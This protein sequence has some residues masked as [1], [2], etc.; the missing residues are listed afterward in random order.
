MI[1][2]SEFILTTDNPSQLITDATARL[3]LLVVDDHCLLN[4]T[5]SDAFTESEGFVVD[6]V[7]SVDEAQAMITENGRYDVVLL[8]YNVP[9]MGALLGLSLLINLN[10]GGVVL[11]SGIANRIV[12]ERALEAGASG[13]IPKTLALKTLGHA[14]RL[15]AHGGMY[16]P[17]EFMLRSSWDDNHNLGLKPREMSVLILLCEGMQNKEIGRE[18]GIE[19]SIVKM[20]V[21]SI[22]RKLG[23]RNRTQAAI[24]ANKNGIV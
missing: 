19:E 22:C 4:E 21:K 14:V 16:V 23:V 6:T 3:R 5:L 18:I 15:V 20:D 8:D 7:V 24:A 17:K 13:F 11:F 9:G 1:P 2:E 12:V 10:N